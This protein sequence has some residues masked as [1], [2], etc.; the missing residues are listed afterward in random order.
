MPA[1][2][3][4]LATTIGVIAVWRRYVASLTHA[5]AIALVLLPFCFVGRALLTAQVYAPIDMPFLSEP[6]KDYARD[7]G[8]TREHNPALSDNYMQFIPW[9]HSVRF[10]V[11]RGVWP[12]L[13]NPFLLCGSILAP[14]MQSE[15]YD[16][17]HVLSFL[18]P[19][20]QAL[21]YGAAMTFFL[22]AFFSFFFAR[23]LGLREVPSLIAASAYT[24]C[25]TLAFFVAVPLGRT[26]CL[27]PF[28]LLAVRMV[29]RENTIRSAVLLTTVF[30]LAIVAGHP[31]SL[32]QVITSG[33]IY[34]AFEIAIAR[35]VKP[36][37]TAVVCGVIALL[38]TAIALLPFF[39]VAPHTTEYS[40][41]QNFYK[42]KPLPFPPQHVG[43]RAAASVFPWYAG[44]PERDK[45]TPPWDPTVIR[46]GSV[47]LALALAALVLAPRRETWFFFILAV[48]TTWIGLNAWP[49]AHLLHELP[50][51]DIA[52]NERFAITACFALAMLAGI[53]ADAWP[54]SRGRAF[55]ATAI[56][57]GV[58]VAL[59][60]GT[61]VVRP[62]VQRELVTF[63]IA[64]ELIPLAILAV[65]FAKRTRAPIAIPLILALV[66]AERTLVDGSIFPTLP[67]KMFYPKVP[68]L[69]TILGDQTKPFRVAG[70]HFSFLPDTAAL[71]GLEEARGYEAMTFDRLSRTFAFWCRYQPISFNNITDKQKPFLS[72][73]NVKY[74][75]AHKRE[76]PDAQWRLVQ[77]D[78]DSRLFE[79][80]RVIPRA[81][82]PPR[83]Q[84]DEDEDVVIA[85]M[86][87]TYDFSKIAFITAPEY[88]SHEIVNGP[89]KVRVRRHTFGYDLVA[90]MQN[91]GWV[92]VSESAWPGWR[93]YVDGKRVRPHF[94][95][96][97]F[98]GVFVPKGTH[99]V[100]LAYEP[101]P[102]TLGRNITLA[103][104]A[105]L[106]GFFAFRRYRRQ[107]P[108]AVGV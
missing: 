40:I 1:I 56:V 57:I 42:D 74:L 62:E 91:E 77:E 45:V 17:V 60:I 14:N 24:F 35:K 96:H 95:N 46:V 89:G 36:V 58:G 10:A 88:P 63:L 20:P 64:V 59:A 104:I 85:R 65:L 23:A 3:L 87:Q 90:E 93:A 31:E 44:Q 73:L 72:F 105:A 67:A 70:L 100:R 6:L 13:W 26:W 48:C 7:Y 50:V 101:E 80:T 49:L 94:A 16:P 61:R 19:H 86:A 47:A 2:V 78:R 52:V 82:V 71:Y 30:V 12:P 8:I 38:L 68:L 39:D 33:A 29:V 25:A 27:L 81:F 54:Q 103:T 28:A 21:T 83:V 53:A 108:R 92:V 15:P 102:Y 32:M 11:Q 18:L 75:L 9:Q 84:Y 41:R 69:Q 51:F 66:L 79:N 106:L 22:A 98:L 37:L 43:E 97:A 4:Y 34:G 55:A 76:Q 5:A 99:D 107:H